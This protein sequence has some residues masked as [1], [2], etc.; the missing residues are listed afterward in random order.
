MLH[1]HCCLI[2]TEGHRNPKSW[3]SKIKNGE[4]FIFVRCH[5]PN[6]RKLNRNNCSLTLHKDHIGDTKAV[7]KAKFL[8]LDHFSSSLLH[9]LSTNHYL[10]GL[11]WVHLSTNHYLSKILFPSTTTRNASLLNADILQY[12]E[13]IVLKSVNKKRDTT[14]KTFENLCR[15]T[16]FLRS[17][18]NCLHWPEMLVPKRC[19]LKKMHKLR[20]YMI[21]RRLLC[22]K[23]LELAGTFYEY[24]YLHLAQRA[25]ASETG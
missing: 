11:D 14:N 23:K 9:T 2:A 10:M 4:E 8:L 25:P 12:E 15:A 20:N 1:K 24:L 3:V 19:K 17:K 21:G 6:A 5:T 18:T 7:P 13:Q 16:I 22:L